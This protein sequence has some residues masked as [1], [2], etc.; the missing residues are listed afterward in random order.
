V[1][2][3]WESSTLTSTRNK[4][5]TNRAAATVAREKSIAAVEKT[6]EKRANLL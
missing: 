6:I 1:G 5:K 3:R 2:K 4:S